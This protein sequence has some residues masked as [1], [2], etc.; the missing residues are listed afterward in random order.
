MTNFQPQICAPPIYSIR[1]L[2]V[3][4]SIFHCFPLAVD[5]FR[6]LDTSEVSGAGPFSLHV[7]N[8]R[9]ATC[10]LFVCLFFP[11]NRIQGC[12]GARQELSPLSSYTPSLSNLVEKSR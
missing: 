9:V 5:D 6:I 12:V 8:L 10:F 4:F 1:K 11:S 2:K 7:E 3:Y